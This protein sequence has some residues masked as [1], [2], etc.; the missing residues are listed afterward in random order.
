[1]LN[2]ISLSTST[3]PGV[4][5][6]H[7]CGLQV[8]QK[9]SLLRGLHAPDN[10]AGRVGSLVVGGGG[11]YICVIQLTLVSAQSLPVTAFWN[12]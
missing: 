10:K 3:V 8:S 7:I 6:L 4:Q 1:M 9:L 12:Y 2:S 5:D 11:L